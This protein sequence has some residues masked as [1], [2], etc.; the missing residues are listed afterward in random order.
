MDELQAGIRI[1]GRN[2]NLRL[3]DITLMTES[4]EEL[5]RPL[6]KVKEESE[7][8]HFRL[9]LR[10]KNKKQKTTK[11][12]ASGPITSWQIEGEKVE[13]VTDF[14]FL[15]S[16]ITAD[17]DCSH[18]IERQLLFGRKAVSNLDSV[19]KIKNITLPTKVHIV[20]IM[21]LPVVMYGCESWTVRRQSAK[22][23][24]FSNCVAAEDS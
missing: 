22:E 3:V 17:Y 16:K 19:L 13:A 9:N 8:A 18:E 12:K 21:V 14:L 24:I 7:K 10:K 5:M 15:G 2:N 11:I 4:K 23:L 1:A 20:N 6:M